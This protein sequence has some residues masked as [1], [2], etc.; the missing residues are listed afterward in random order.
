MLPP[1]FTSSPPQTPSTVSRHDTAKSHS[2]RRLN[3][4]TSSTSLSYTEIRPKPATDTDP[5]SGHILSRNTKRELRVRSYH[6]I[7]RSAE[8]HTED[9]GVSSSGNA[10]STGTA[11]LLRHPLDSHGSLH[12]WFC[13]RT[14]YLFTATPQ[15]RS[16]DTK[17]SYQILQQ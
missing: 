10:P 4:S 7:R 15:N 9:Q 5:F 17:S 3:A 11:R 8:T 12:I 13:A 2:G 6:Q 1:S 14:Y 16:L